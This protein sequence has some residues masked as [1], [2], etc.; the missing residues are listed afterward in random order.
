MNNYD[1]IARWNPFMS[2]RAGLALQAEYD[3]LQQIGAGPASPVT[4]LGTAL[5]SNEVLLG[6][7]FDF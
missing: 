3:L 7:D 1:F 6:M 2:S 4:G 5:N